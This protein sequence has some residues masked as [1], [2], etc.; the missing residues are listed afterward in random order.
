M[1]LIS[2]MKKKKIYSP[3]RLFH[4]KKEDIFIIVLTIDYYEEVKKEL[5]YNGFE[6]NK[7]FIGIKELIFN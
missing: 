1:M 7:N 5:I 3:Q 2:W 4:E 6:E